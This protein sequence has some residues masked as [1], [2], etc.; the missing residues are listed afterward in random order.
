MLHDDA[1]DLGKLGCVVVTR[2]SHVEWTDGKTRV[3]MGVPKPG[4]YVQ[5]ARSLKVLRAGFKTRASA[6]AFEK[7]FYSPSGKGWRELTGGIK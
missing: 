4:W 3:G 6:L 1:V 5:S 2:A 7:S